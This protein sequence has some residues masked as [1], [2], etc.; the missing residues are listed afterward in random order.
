MAVW[1]QK[2]VRDALTEAPPSPS[3]ASIAAP[4][5]RE[6]LDP[7]P[8]PAPP[9]S[10]TPPPTLRREWLLLAL[11]VGLLLA[12]V[13]P[14]LVNLGRYQHRIVQSMSRSLGREVT[15]RAV[16][17]R[18]LPLPA[19]VLTD[20]VV[21]EDPAFG[22]EPALRAPSVIAQVRVAS[23]WRGRLEVSRVEMSDASLN[24]V[25]DPSGR[26]NVG[27][28]LLQASH[29]R[30][31][32]TGQSR[33]GSAPR[34]PYIQITDSRINVKE[35]VEKL[36]YSLLNA[37]LSMWLAEP[38][39]WQLRLEGQPVRTDVDLGLSDTGTLRVQGRLHRASALGLMPLALH[40]EWSGAPLGQATRLLLGSDRG[41]R[42]DLHMTAD[43]L[44]D[45]DA[46][47][48]NTH[49]SIANLHREE[50]TP[51]QAFTV[52]AS[53]KAAYSRA[54]QLLSNLDCRWPV[55]EGLLQLSGSLSAQDESLGSSPPSRRGSPR[56]SPPA[57]S[58]APDSTL[59]LSV[60]QLPASFL[61]A[62]AGLARSEFAPVF[63]LQGTLSGTLF[64]HENRTGAPSYTG[65]LQGSPLKLTASGLDE[66][67]LLTDLRLTAST[68]APSGVS[69]LVLTTAPLDL[70]GAAP[71]LIHAQ[72][73][74]QGFLLHAGGSASLARLE[75][76][77]QATHL[78]P[79]ALARLGPQGSAEFDVTRTASWQASGAPVSLEPVDPTPAASPRQPAR[80]ASGASSPYAPA[81]VTSGWLRLHNAEYAP[82]F[83]PEP[84]SLLS[85]QAT[86]LPG[87][88]T[89]SVPSAT[90]HQASMQL[91]ATYPLD[92]TPAEGCVTRFRLASAS[93][94]GDEL[95]AALL[96]ARSR[97]PLFDQL[98]SRGDTPS[99]SWPALEGS[100]HADTFTLGR[101]SLHNAEAALSI[102]DGRASLRS[103]DAAALGGTLHS[104]GVISTKDH[105]PLY[106]VSIVLSRASA[107][108]V[109]ALLHENWGAGTLSFS[110]QLELAGI[111]P[112]E[113]AHSATGQFH[114]EWLHGGLGTQTPLARF[115]LWSA[116]GQ[117]RNQTLTLL[118]GALTLG[119][120]AE[121]LPLQGSIAFDRS[122]ALELG[123]TGTLAPDSPPVTLSGTLSHPTE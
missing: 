41:W 14:P 98:L 94:N 15:L 83:L 114:A 61:V 74:S 5:A 13:V 65:S 31:A 23:L 120:P 66:P 86:F 78:L 123:R 26:W 106:N 103:L 71:S 54:A 96:G 7:P 85:A 45:L 88:I 55:G 67:L 107:A 76:L 17:L 19:L 16:T 84:V 11:S 111:G 27:S 1:P 22:A 47:S 51:P 99:S 112:A 28:I 21:N 36:P 2:P 110:S 91:S 35:G 87:E 77:G 40:A 37:D 50:F 18:L 79:T 89:W 116:D 70:G 62:A 43:V 34:F 42:G 75:A 80:I 90:F 72:L 102:A 82:R 109:G 38:S 104:E 93:F 8:F 64:Y 48:I 4:P 63:R 29:V 68:P 33:A 52:D 56:N 95:F 118:H 119:S 9:T 3:L 81:A 30:N 122:I 20:V 97:Q 12:V 108:A 32:P 121:L 44:G 58:P 46:L 10:L 73:T 57:A 25:R 115:T 39:I 113:L 49:V 100:V 105:A 53:C 24:L 59:I 60:Q 101:L 69:T 92:C 117:I 6:S